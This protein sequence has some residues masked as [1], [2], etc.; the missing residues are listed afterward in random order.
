MTRKRTWELFDELVRL[1]HRSPKA[2]DVVRWM[3][4]TRAAAQR[5]IRIHNARHA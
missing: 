3:P 2:T 1:L 4:I 5:M